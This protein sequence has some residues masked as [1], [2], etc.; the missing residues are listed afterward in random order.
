MSQR[1]LNKAVKWSWP[2]LQGHDN[3]TLR[4]VLLTER[5][6]LLYSAVASAVYWK[7]RWQD[8][9]SSFA[10]VEHY[11][12]EA[13]KRLLMPIDICEL[14][15]DCIRN[16]ADVQEAI[17]GEAGNGYG[18]KT[19]INVTQYTNNQLIS[20]ETDANGCG[21]DAKFGRVIALVEY[22][23]EVMTDFFQS[24]DAATNIISQFD[25]LISAAPVFET[26]PIDEFVG[27]IGNTGEFWR[28]SYDASVNTQLLEGIEC[29]LWCR[30]GANCEI[31]VGDLRQLILDRYNFSST[32]GS[33]NV[34]SAFAVIA[35]IATT[36]LSGGLGTYI[37]DD[38]VYL[39]WLLQ[40][41]AI[42]A[43]GTFFGV[44]PVDYVSEASNGTP[45]TSWALCACPNSWIY[46]ID[47]TQELG[48]FQVIS[49]V[50]VSG[51]G[52]QSGTQFGSEASWIRDD[53][54]IDNALTT[55][56]SIVITY[57]LTSKCDN[58]NR[59][60]LAHVPNYSNPVRTLNSLQT[61]A[62]TLECY[63][64]GND[65]SIRLRN[66]DSGSCS[67]IYITRIKVAG[68][69]VDPFA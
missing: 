67:N 52:I 32:Q 6:I 43:T 26:L 42:E 4:V 65:V 21:N 46:E 27:A 5:D 53:V 63:T 2:E 60:A 12:T 33:L 37:G 57:E 36:I 34:F 48:K 41:S 35:R 31:T 7:T 28:D 20:G 61:G 18:P 9:P 14:V 56:T 38:F 45:N 66:T 11:A 25:E 22:V 15:A 50:W 30:Y 13:L 62:K 24:L 1:A 59:W 40:L 39:S 58:S 44:D 69:G 17:Q 10:D 54:T 64:A 16:N 8:A 47:L 55:V 29:E 51:Q 68:T 23:D 19:I 3:D 49:G